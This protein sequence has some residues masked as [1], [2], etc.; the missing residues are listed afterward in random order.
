MLRSYRDLDVWKR[1]I[2]LAEMVYRPSARFPRHERFGVTS[3]IRRSATS[4]AANIAEGAERHGTRGYL[5]FLGIANGSLAETE[6]YLILAIRLGMVREEQ[7]HPVLD[8][9]EEVGRMLNG[10]KRPLRSRSAGS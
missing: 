10:L 6:T 1:S 5:R 2:D 3:Q 4:V 8:Q 7:I 9:A